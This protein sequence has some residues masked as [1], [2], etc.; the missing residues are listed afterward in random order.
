MAFNVFKLW[1]SKDTAAGQNEFSNADATRRI[2]NTNTPEGEE[3]KLIYV[4][5]AMFAKRATDVTEALSVDP[6]APD[7]GTGASNVIIRFTQKR[8]VSPTVPVL[9]KLIEMFYLKGTDDIYLEGRFGLENTDNPQLDVL[10]LPTAGYKLVSFK[11]EPNQN[12]INITTW[13]LVIKFLGDH[14]KLGTRV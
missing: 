10:P 8:D 3:I 11:M 7:T 6:S 5:P 14:T 12:T 13:E 1:Y 4:I 2:E 9:A